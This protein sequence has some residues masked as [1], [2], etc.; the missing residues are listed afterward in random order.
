MQED[1]VCGS[2]M[3]VSSGAIVDRV[4][5]VE[6]EDVSNRLVYKLVRVEEDGTVVPATEDEVFKMETMLEGDAS[7]GCSE[8]LLGVKGLDLERK[9]LLAQVER[10]DGFVPSYSK[11]GSKLE[12]KNLLLESPD[13]LARERH[14]G[15]EPLLETSTGELEIPCSTSKHSCMGTTSKTVGRTKTKRRP[16][17]KSTSSEFDNREPDVLKGKVCLDSLSIRE[18]HDTFQR[19]FGRQTSVKDKQWLKRR[20]SLGLCEVASNNAV[21]ADT[22]IDAVDGGVSGARCGMHF[23]AEQPLPAIGVKEVIGNKMPQVVVEGSA[24][25]KF[26]G[27]KKRSPRGLRPL[28]ALHL[29]S[30]NSIGGN[31][32]TSVNKNQLQASE[33]REG[34]RQLKPTKRYIEELESSDTRAGCGH[35]SGAKKL[36][37]G[38]VESKSDVGVCSD[39]LENER[40]KSHLGVSGLKFATGYRNHRGRPNKDCNTVVKSK[41]TER[42]AQLVRKAISTRASRHSDKESVPLVRSKVKPVT[43][44]LMHRPCSIDPQQHVSGMDQSLALVMH[45]GTG[46]KESLALAPRLT[47]DEHTET[48][49][50]RKSGMRRKHHR[51]WTIREVMK[52]VEGVAHCGV[53]K[54]AEIKKLAFYN[55]VYRTSVDLKDKWRNLLR[56]SDAY[57]QASK[58]GEQR[59]KHTSP[60]IPGPLL[61]RVCELAQFQAQSQ[62]V[63]IESSVSR[64]GRTVHKRHVL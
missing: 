13:K 60:A 12:N 15:R 14:T 61:L 9:K 39:E 43:G 35:S 2:H 34:K 29:T 49:R 30:F 16:A 33:I 4:E 52:L 22:W 11:L 51:P 64:S 3:Q 6:E 54:W 62:T 46:S 10:L 19:T 26:L 5:P 47:S 1:Q 32:D 48:I 17:S 8:G 27:H 42:A 24:A 45:S 37:D 21:A 56:A 58:Q 36:G 57:L 50:T 44:Q 7:A 55:S 18:L 28:I 23:S 53:G 31:A 59:R 25:P 41:S 63:S 38:G 20:I 40:G